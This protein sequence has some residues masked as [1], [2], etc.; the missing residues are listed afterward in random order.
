MKHDTFNG[1]DLGADAIRTFR[2]VFGLLNHTSASNRMLF[3]D[4]YARRR[5]ED[6]SPGTLADVETTWTLLD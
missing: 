5:H 3:H 4:S 2:Q 1:E 6:T